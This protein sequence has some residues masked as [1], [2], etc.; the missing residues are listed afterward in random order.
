M[1]ACCVVGI[2]RSTY[3]LGLAV[4]VLLP[5]GKLLLQLLN[6]SWHVCLSAWWVDSDLGQVLN[7]AN[8]KVELALTRG[9]WC[10][11]LGFSAFLALLLVLLLGLRL[12]PLSWG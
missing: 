12:S 10:R 4:L 7:H 8:V 5:V 1:I 9:S 11:A 6:H 2:C 3:L